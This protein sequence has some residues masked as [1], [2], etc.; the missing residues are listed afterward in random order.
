M[1]KNILLLSCLLA[2]A[3]FAYADSVQGEVYI[4]PQAK[5]VVQIKQ[6]DN[7]KTF[8]F[9]ATDFSQLKSTAPKSKDLIEVGEV[10]ASG[11][12]FVPSSELDW[13]VD[14]GL[15]S[16]EVIIELTDIAAFRASLE[17]KLLNKA[18]AVYA[19][20]PADRDNTWTQINLA[21]SEE[22]QWLPTF[23]GTKLGLYIEANEND[24]SD[25]SVY[26]P[27]VLSYYEA[28][29]QSR[30]KNINQLGDSDSCEVDVACN[31]SGFTD[32][33]D[34][35]A[36]YTFVSAGRGYLCSGSL[37]NDADTSTTIPYFL[38]GRTLCI[39]CF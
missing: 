30:L 29:L 3:S 33:Q 38:T 8:R 5:S 1:K 14:N 17:T 16:A 36:K 15:A 6:L 21:N 24:S 12:V 23:S 27:K 4:A 13:V 22:L 18:T 35:V 26:I 2:G 19:F 28:D 9:S 31:N 20:A 10:L 32:Q 25:I 11:Q 37:I 34:A 7:A 39:N